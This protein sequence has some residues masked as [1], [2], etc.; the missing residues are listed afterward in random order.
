MLRWSVV[1][2]TT[3]D[4][5]IAHLEKVKDND[6]R[7]RERMRAKIALKNINICMDKVVREMAHGETSENY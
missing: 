6:S 4:R 1:K 7:H 2:A 5:I 3:L